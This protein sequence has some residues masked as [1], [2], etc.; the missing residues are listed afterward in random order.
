[1][2]K[3]LEQWICDVCGEIIECPEE[4]YV[5]WS[6]DTDLRSHSFK[7][8]HQG[9]CDDRHTDS[10]IALPDLLGLNGMSQL[11]ALIT[12]GPLKQPERFGGNT[13]VKDLEEYVDLFRRLQVPHY[14]AARQRFRDPDIL[15]R[16][17]DSN[18]V[19]PYRPD[20][21]ERIASGKG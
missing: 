19:Y 12:V 9:K 2:L 21:L 8:I 5:V 10:S 1:M 14:E 15:E 13:G 6:V 4:G 11:L 20:V 7:I 16:F 18:E 17:Y 3:P